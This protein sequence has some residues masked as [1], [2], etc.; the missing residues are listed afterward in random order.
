MRKT[1][2]QFKKFKQSVWQFKFSGQRAWLPS[3]LS[4]P[5]EMSSDQPIVAKISLNIKKI[6]GGKKKGGK[7][8]NK[9]LK[10][11][12]VVAYRIL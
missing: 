3:E 2:E 5:L 11:Y 10:T 9:K 7:V 1:S 6:G 12:R 8:K 4:I